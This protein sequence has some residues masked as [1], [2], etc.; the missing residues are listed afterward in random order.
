MAQGRFSADVRNWTEK[1]RANIKTVR[2]EATQ[3]VITLMQ[4]PVGAGGRM[5]VD[6]GFLRASLRTTIG[7]ANFAVVDR[8]DGGGTYTWDAGEVSLIIA[9]A[10][11]TDPIEAVYTAK[12]AR[13]RE[14]GA[15]GQPP[16]RFVALAA[17]QWPRIVA[18]VAAEIGD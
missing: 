4:T 10:K 12:Y 14:Y 3:R 16:D 17:Q 8:P 2:D 9:S 7:S 6:T 18:D 5:R 13:H 11:I 1:A 15:R